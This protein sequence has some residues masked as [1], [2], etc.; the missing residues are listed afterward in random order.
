VRVDAD[1]P[2]GTTLEVTVATSEK[3]DKDKAQ[4]NSNDNPEWKDFAAG[5][6]HSKDWQKLPAA[7]VTDFL[8]DQPPGRYIFLRMRLTGDGQATPLVRRIRIDFPRSTS[9]EFLPSVYRENPRAEDFT[10][11][12]LSLFDAAIADLDRAIDLYPALLDIQGTPDEVLPWLGSFLDLV[13]ESG[14]TPAKR[15][16]VLRELPRLYKWRGTV[17]GLARAIKVI[18]EV[19]PAI[20][21]LAYGRSWGGLNHDARLNSTRLFGKARA[22]FRLGSSALSRAPLR[23]FGNPDRDPLEADAYRFRVTLPS[24]DLL[25]K[26]GRERLQRLIESQ[27]PAH[28]LASIRVGG[29]GWVLGNWSAVGVDTSFS[30]LPA[31]VLGPAGNVRLNRM[32][33]LWSGPRGSRAGLTIGQASIGTKT[34]MK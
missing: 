18:F 16:S 25:T 17:A 5:W 12:F 27:K 3:F 23:S 11:R 20:Q 26:M 30:P 31:P 7:G 8:I 6:P 29:A 10:E 2:A 1:I 14:W 15:R 34:V 13:F 32:S 22:R 4:G 28:T 24:S 19:E 33:V 9:L 21:E